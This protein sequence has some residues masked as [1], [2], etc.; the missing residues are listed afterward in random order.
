[1][2]KVMKG[3]T[4]IELMVVI[5]IIA[6][7][8][9]IALPNYEEYV[10]KNHEKLV[11]QK[12]GDIGLQLEKEKTRNFSYE[13]FVLKN[14]DKKIMRNNSS[15][16]VIYNISVNAELQKWVVVGCVNSTLS[17]ASRYNNFAQNS[18]GA[19][20]EWIDTTCALPDECK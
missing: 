18:H 7:I 10:R 8:A 3:F 19:K 20:C 14:I 9:A 13:G 2:M 12:I 4:L 17:N 5:V 6:I 11:V 15:T 1:M 16:D